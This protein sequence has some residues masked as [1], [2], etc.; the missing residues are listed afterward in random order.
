ME[1]K[2]KVMHFLSNGN[3]MVT[4][5][6]KSYSAYDLQYALRLIYIFSTIFKVQIQSKVFLPTSISK[7][8]VLRSPHIDKKSREQFEQR[9]HT[10]I[11]VVT[12][13]PYQ[14]IYA[15]LELLKRV[16]PCGINL[17]LKFKAFV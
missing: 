13:L 11:V 16:I 15:W 14:E 7:Y 17:T 8:T 10:A 1:N 12:A 4:L 5:Q 3:L 2:E 9:R 6:V